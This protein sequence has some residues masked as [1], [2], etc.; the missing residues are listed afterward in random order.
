MEK[1]DV[2]DRQHG[3][4]I[5]VRRHPNSSSS[6]QIKTEIILNFLNSFKGLQKWNPS[7]RDIKVAHHQGLC[8]GGG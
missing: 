3:W 5:R 8:I 2:E 6:K 4:Y 7:Q 1:C